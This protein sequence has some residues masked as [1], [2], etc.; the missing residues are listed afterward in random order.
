MSGCW[1][2]ID[3]EVVHRNAPCGGGGPGA[4]RSA[5]Q[6]GADIDRD[7]VAD[8]DSP[9]G[10]YAVLSEEDKSGLRL[11]A[12]FNLWF[13]IIYDG[14]RERTN[15]ADN[16]PDL[17]AVA[18]DLVQFRKDCEREGMVN[19]P[20]SAHAAVK[21]AIEDS[22][23]DAFAEWDRVAFKIARV[24]A[25]DELDPTLEKAVVAAFCQ[26]VRERLEAEFVK[27]RTAFLTFSEDASLKNLE[28]LKNLVRV[29][30]ALFGDL[31]KSLS[32]KEGLLRNTLEKLRRKGIINDKFVSKRI[33]NLWTNRLEG[34]EGI[35]KWL[36]KI[37]VS[38]YVVAC[39]VFLTPATVATGAGEMYTALDALDQ[40][41][42]QKFWKLNPLLNDSDL[43]LPELPLPR[44]H[45][46][47]MT[48]ASL[49]ESRYNPLEVPQ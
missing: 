47:S 23:Q 15:K 43:L 49:E 27:F 36:L 19:R 40:T 42:S 11:H 45:D 41:V 29:G 10:R 39:R 16:L 2:T 18:A 30:E 31:A 37:M 28:S 14:L 21:K 13:K 22:I 1:V 33:R 20:E 25:D 44:S 34:C 12:S 8:P 48:R 17:L 46:A 32:D 4:F 26:V 7:G 6:L 9:V 24:F 3:G 38:P 5:E 35:F